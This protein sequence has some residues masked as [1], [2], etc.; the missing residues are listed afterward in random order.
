M[1]TQPLLGLVAQPLGVLSPRV[2]RGGAPV[3]R[4]RGFDT[5]A[6]ACR[7]DVLA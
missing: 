3:T 2:H 7:K 5:L 1:A 6:E 4:P